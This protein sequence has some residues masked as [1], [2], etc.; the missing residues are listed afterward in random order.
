MI[1]DNFPGLMGLPVEQKK[2][3][4]RELVQSVEHEEFP[5][6]TAEAIALLEKSFQDY[7]ADPS[8][9]IPW[10]EAQIRLEQ[11]KAEIRAQRG[12]K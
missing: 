8:L 10:E 7:I 2:E 4:I 5:E 11:R 12:W 6:L 1:S 9:G 3:L